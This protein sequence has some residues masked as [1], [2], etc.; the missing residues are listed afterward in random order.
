MNFLKDGSVHQLRSYGLNVCPAY[1]KTKAPALSTWTWLQSQ[2]PEDSVVSGWDWEGQLIGFF[3]GPVSGGLE[4]LDFDIPGKHDSG[5]VPGSVPSPLYAPWREAVQSLGGEDLLSRLALDVSR[6][7][8]VHA[9]WRCSV[10]REH[11]GGKKKLAHVPWTVDGVE[12]YKDCIE[13]LSKG[14]FCVCPPSPGYEVTQG[15]FSAIPEITPDER[16]LLLM[17]ARMVDQKPPEPPS[18]P[19]KNLPPQGLGTRPGDDFNER[20]TWQEALEG[21]EFLPGHWQGQQYVRRPGKREGKSGHVGIGTTGDHLLVYTTATAL[22]E[23]RS[24]SKFAAYAVLSHGG[25]YSAAART[26]SERGYGS[27]EIRSSTPQRVDIEEW[28]SPA[29]ARGVSLY[30]FDEWRSDLSIVTED[31]KT[32]YPKLDEIALIPEGAMTL[33]AGRTGMG[34]TTMLLNLL[35][36]MVENDS[37]DG[38]YLFFSYEEG[39]KILL[40]KLA[41]AMTGKIFHDPKKNLSAYLMKIREGD[42]T[43]APEF[44]QALDK[45]KD[46]TESGRVIFIDEPLPSDQLVATI[47]ATIEERP[48]RAVFVD[49]IQKVRPPKAGQ[50]RYLEVGEASEALRALAVSSGVPVIAGAQLG[51]SQDKD[52]GKGRG[53]DLDGRKG[54]PRL[55]NLRESGNLEQDANLVIGVHREQVKIEEDSLEAEIASK[56]TEPGDHKDDME[57]YI[58]K[59]RNGRTGSLTMDF[60]GPTYQICAKREKTA[61]KDL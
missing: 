31:R 14:S 52:G 48:V 47:Q 6:S 38:S 13:L 19:P 50:A 8:G 22:E 28:S 27:Q 35:R 15:S 2:W 42:W 34:K 57:I 53:Q 11:G 25:D 55:D 41:M 60:I 20:G 40:A 33:I 59:N 24:Y 46:W 44:A 54:R 36:G 3:C 7:G 49:Y 45:L 21:W 23:R 16:D 39:R 4:A 1:P 58:L 30:T 18:K 10:N 26:L 61:E 56:S 5:F 9:Y 17:A 29:P 43:A 37:E 32:G 12:G 51:R